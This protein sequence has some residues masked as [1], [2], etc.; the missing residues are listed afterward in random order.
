MESSIEYLNYALNK[1]ET[2]VLAADC[3]IEYSGRAE[4]FLPQG[5]RV[6]L[7]K[8]DKAM[9]VHQPEGNAPVNY[10]KPGSSFSVIRGDDGN[11]CLNSRN[12]ANKEFLTV[13][14]FK[15]HF[16]NSHPLQDGHKIQLVGSEKDMSE[17]IYN[18]PELIEKGFKPYSMEEQTK[19]GF[20]DVFG[21]DK[22]GKVVIVECKR[23]CADLGAVQQLRRYVEKVQASKG[24][25]ASQIRGFV[26]APK[27]T[28]NAEQMLKDWGFQFVA[29]NPPKYRE[30]FD[31]KQSNLLNF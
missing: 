22:D 2:I 28:S 23:Y 13:K 21:Q 4:A 14:L 1:N 7:I 12:L 15:I 18:N 25:E 3:E 20:I 24:I 17:M 11:Y 27:I 26:A 30:K 31:K 10:M 5:E 16:V 29:V 6:I 9:L 8:S 19:Y